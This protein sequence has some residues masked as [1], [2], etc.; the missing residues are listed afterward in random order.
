MRKH[1]AKIKRPLWVAG[2]NIALALTVGSTQAFANGS[3]SITSQNDLETIGVVVDVEGVESTPRP[4]GG[5]YVVTESFGVVAPVSGGSTYVAGNF[6]GTFDGGGFIISGLTKPLFEV[7]DSGLNPI[8]T[9]ISDLTL[10]ADT[11]GVSGAGILAVEVYPGTAI[12]NVDV[13]GNVFG[14]NSVGSLVGYNG[15]TIS[16]SSSIGDVDGAG[17]V[18]GLVGYNDGGTITNSYAT[19]EVNGLDNVGGLVGYNDGGTITNS[20]ATGAVTGTEDYVGGL[21]GYSN[22]DISNSYATGDVNG[23]NYVGGFVG[24]TGTSP[25]PSLITNSYATGDVTGSGEYIGGLVGDSYGTITNSY[26]T[27]NVTGNETGLGDSSLYDGVG[28]LVGYLGGTLSNTYATGIVRGVNYVGGLVGETGGFAADISNSYATGDVTGS[29]GVGGLVGLSD[30]GITNSYSTGDVTGSGGVGGLVGISVGDIAN[31]SATGDVNGELYVGGLVG[32][33]VGDITISYA[34]GDVIGGAV[35]GGLV[36]ALTVGA[37]IA[38]TGVYD[39][40]IYDDTI[41]DCDF[42]DC[43]IG[44]IGYSYSTGDVSGSDTIGG[45]V[46]GIQGGYL[47]NEFELHPYLY[48]SYAVGDVNGESSV[49]GLVG[50]IQDSSIEY[51]LAS[52]DVNGESSVGGL[53]GLALEE[54]YISN[55]GS[56]GSVTGSGDNVGGLVGLNGDEFEENVTDS[57][58]LNNPDFPI[59]LS[60][61]LDLALEVL[62]T[63]YENDLNF[64]ITEDLNGGLPYLVFNPPFA[65]ELELALSVL[66][67]GYEYDPIFAITSNLNGGLPYLISNNP[68]SDED[69]VVDD[70]PRYNFSFLST[71]VLDVLKK[72]VGFKAAKS[73]LSKLNL[74]LFDQVKGDKSAQIIGA[75]LFSYQ[76]LSTSLSAGSIFQLEI[77][78]EASKSLQVWVKSSDD[79]YVLLGDITF[80][81]DGNAVLPGIE[82]KKSGSYELIFVNSDKKDLTQPEL[83]NKVS[84][85]TV[86]V[87]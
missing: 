12:D 82:F 62:N 45:L 57:F 58:D 10:I 78:Y 32:I 87:N 38:T 26:A 85:L 9:H 77:N 19:G 23:D 41:N 27:G 8:V 86:Y 43:F 39:G 29:G 66:N 31:T 84:G 53:V 69:E 65:D 68:F 50:G 30:V 73:D 80:D 28:G 4:L 13:T 67:T 34:T 54:S 48:N 40:I 63:G 24:S 35:V 52:G 14:E 72:S 49:G 46:G 2:L 37:I 7:I 64:A 21:V 71:Q 56:V 47:L 42:N 11:D 3:Y 5:N 15:G 55:S 83:V 25:N 59:P 22:G 18:G 70:S 60:D 36:G 75:K 74:A 61:Y 17:N 1:Y 16:Y 6:T 33:S 79:Q 51:S 20:Y 44:S 76:S 81:K